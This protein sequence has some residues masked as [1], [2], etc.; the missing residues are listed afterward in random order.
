[1]SRLILLALSLVLIILIA[2]CS[3]Q[4]TGQAIVTQSNGQETV[5]QSSTP[6]IPTPQQTTPQQPQEKVY[7][8]GDTI[9]KD[10][11]SFTLKGITKHYCDYSYSFQD[12]SS[13]SCPINNQ[14]IC[15]EIVIYQ[16]KISDAILA[17]K[18]DEED[19]LANELCDKYGQYGKK[20]FKV[21]ISGEKVKI[22]DQNR[23]ITDDM[24]DIYVYDTCNK[25]L[26]SKVWLPYQ[27]GSFM[28]YQYFY[29]SKLFDDSISELNCPLKIIYQGSGG[30]PNYEGNLDISDIEKMFN[31]FVF[32]V[33]L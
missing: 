14:D 29:A 19:R 13:N 22:T 20:F 10:G 6:S 1:M 12:F 9:N 23:H 7:G 31:T 5:Q 18:F 33:N 8:I 28:E 4:P 27:S 30:L 11:F 3:K 2:G 25:K 26:Y 24:Y 15:K 32:T 17:I 16:N 21:E